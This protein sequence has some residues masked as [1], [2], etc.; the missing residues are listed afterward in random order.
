MQYLIQEF[1]LFYRV[2][3]I[4]GLGFGGNKGRD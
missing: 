2:S 3:R 1:G 4:E